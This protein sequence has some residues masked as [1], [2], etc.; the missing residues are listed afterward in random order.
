MVALAQRRPVKFTTS[1]VGLESIAWQSLQNAQ[2]PPTAQQTRSYLEFY[3][4]PYAQPTIAPQSHAGVYGASVTGAGDFS[5]YESRDIEF[6]PAPPVSAVLTVAYIPPEQGSDGGIKPRVEFFLT[7]AHIQ[8]LHHSLR[9]PVDGVAP[10]WMQ[11]APSQVVRSKLGRA[12]EK[13]SSVPAASSCSSGPVTAEAM[14]GSNCGTVNSKSEPA[15]G[16]VGTERTA[17]HS[18]VT[19]TSTHTGPTG[20]PRATEEANGDNVGSARKTGKQPLRRSTRASTMASSKAATRRVHPRLSVPST[21]VPLE[22]ADTILLVGRE[23][24]LL[25]RTTAVLEHLLPRAVIL[26]GISN[27]ALV[28]ADQV[29]SIREHVLWW[30]LTVDFSLLSF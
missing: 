26:G 21:S 5:A 18:G 8:Y 2:P 25:K 16:A 13:E 1:A 22:D 7:D 24:N 20:P 27:C 4:I 29:Q 23:D 28:I 9:P 19:G 6:D 17:H 14:D 11:R 12:K 30:D 3:T 15:G 10:V